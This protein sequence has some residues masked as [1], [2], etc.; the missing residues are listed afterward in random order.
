MRDRMSTATQRMIK[1]RALAMRTIL[2]AFSF[3]VYIWSEALAYVVMAGTA[4]ACLHDTDKPALI[5]S[6]KCIKWTAGGAGLHSEDAAVRS[7]RI[8]P[9]AD[10]CCRCDSPTNCCC[11]NQGDGA[12]VRVNA[13][14][15]R[16]DKPSPPAPPTPPPPLVHTMTLSLCGPG[17]SVTDTCLTSNVLNGI[18]TEIVNFK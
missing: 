4:D 7:A 11:F 15:Q 10:W 12:E 16:K 5:G 6:Y 1:P 9:P 8:P 18:E 14:S 3:P 2:G 13:C 17:P